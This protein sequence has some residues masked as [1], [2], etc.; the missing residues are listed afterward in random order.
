MLNGERVLDEANLPASLK[1]HLHHATASLMERRALRSGAMHPLTALVLLP[2]S[3]PNASP[4]AFY[5]FFAL[6]ALLFVLR[7]LAIVALN[8]HPPADIGKRQLLFLIPWL[9]TAGVYGAFCTW[10]VVELPGSW[11]S[12][13]LCS[14]AGLGGLAAVIYFAAYG[15][16]TL[17]YALAMSGPP[18]LA[19]FFSTGGEG[20]GLVM[21]FMWLV[22]VLLVVPSLVRLNAD[23]WSGLTGSAVLEEQASR[24]V[25]QSSRK[26]RYLANV[27]HDLRTP[28]SGIIGMSRILLESPLDAGARQSALALHRAS[29]SMLDLVNE[30]LDAEQAEAGRFRLEARAFDPAPIIEEVLDLFRAEAASRGVELVLDNDGSL[31]PDLVGDGRRLRQVLQN[32]LTNAV[33][34]TTSGH[35]RVTAH[36]APDLDDEKRVTLSVT[37]A[38][39]G[40]GFASEDAEGLFERFSKAASSH[41]GTSGLGLSLSREIM[42]HMG[43]SLTAASDGV[44]RGATFTLRVSLPRASTEES[45][46]VRRVLLADDDELSLRVTTALLERLGCV[47]ETARSG[48]EAL[49]LAERRPFD[50]YVLDCMM[51]G[52]SGAEVSRALRKTSDAPI[53][54]VTAN[55][56]DLRDACYAAGMDVVVSKPFDLETLRAA[57]LSSSPRAKKR[58][59]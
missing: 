53:V 28:L 55:A 20:P 38:D 31:P 25:Q 19:A 52:L 34:L 37:V 17:A 3:L 15:R 2:S 45:L 42:Q 27:T 59:A 26:S 40:V 6:M 4:R 9:G 11:E 44:G 18:G 32:L 47:V 41:A 57:L 12:V 56:E 1:S 30:L 22:F 39:T 49:A 50:A 35:V 48:P 54:A 21:L 58:V 10:F 36:A 46:G 23:Y 13:A 14:A 8:R 43:G 24:A 16:S 7:S 29:L 51:P 5:G 33:R